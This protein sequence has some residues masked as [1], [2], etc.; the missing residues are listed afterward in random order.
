MDGRY[1]KTYNVSGRHAL[2]KKLAY[3]RT[4]MHVLG[5]PYSVYLVYKSAMNK[6]KNVETLP[7]NDEKSRLLTKI[8]GNERKAS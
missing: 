2:T 6:Q 1:E 8:S 4:S 3:I 7:E 5:Y